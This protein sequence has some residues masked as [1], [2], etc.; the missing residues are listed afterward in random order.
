MMLEKEFNSGNSKVKVSHWACC[1]E[2]HEADGFHYHC[3][4]KLTGV[5]KWLSVKR[6]ITKNHKIV[7]NFSDS[8]SHYIYA[9]RYVC[10]SDTEVAHSPGHP[11]L[12]E[13]GS[14][15]TKASTAALREGSKKRRSASPSSQ[16]C[17]SSK[18]KRRLS[19]LEVCDYVLENNIH[20][21]QELIAKADSRK[22]EGISKAP[23]TADYVNDLF[24]P[25]QS[26]SGSNCRNLEEEL[27]MNYTHFLEDVEG[28]VV[29]A[30]LLCPGDDSLSKIVLHLD[31]F[32]QFVSGSPKV[33]CLGFSTTPSII[34][35][36]VDTQQK[37]SVST[38]GL[39]LYI[40][41]N[42]SSLPAY[43]S[44]KADFHDCIVSSPGFGQVQFNNVTMK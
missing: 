36:H 33:P 11:D 20:N 23:L 42:T 30:E 12:S 9:Y 1:K 25:Q 4:L 43:E 21:L 32:L 38:C 41:V 37:I 27:L 3:C 24:L 17:T 34:F 28:G 8:P 35:N 18:I 6:D 14:P 44:F 26:D 7:V 29:T 40:A 13:V 5:K 19:N 16:N 2:M 31:D 15:R 22:Q 10:K 39:Q